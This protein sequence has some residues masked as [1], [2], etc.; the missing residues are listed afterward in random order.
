MKLV[1]LPVTALLFAPRRTAA[2]IVFWARAPQFWRMLCPDAI[3]AD[4]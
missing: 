4:Q 3:D 1:E 2:V